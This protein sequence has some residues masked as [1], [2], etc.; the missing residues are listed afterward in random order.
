MSISFSAKIYLLCELPR[1]VE[2]L[3]LKQGRF[4][5]HMTPADGKCDTYYTSQDTQLPVRGHPS[6]V[7][8]STL[9]GQA[10]RVFPLA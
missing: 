10:V 3:V 6:T 8:C 7:Q 5:V 2:P 4:P 9:Q 1:E